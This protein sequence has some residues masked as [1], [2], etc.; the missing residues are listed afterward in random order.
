MVLGQKGSPSSD[1]LEIQ[2]KEEKNDKKNVVG[3]FPAK[4]REKTLWSTI[5][6]SHINYGSTRKLPKNSQTK[7]EALAHKNWESIEKGV[8]KLIETLSAAAAAE[9]FKNFA[10]RKMYIH[11]YCI[12]YNISFCLKGNK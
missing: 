10:R 4:G 7:T 1:W 5:I 6:F 8:I 2:C 3:Y 11:T 9:Y 12:A